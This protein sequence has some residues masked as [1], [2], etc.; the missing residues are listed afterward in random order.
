MLRYLLVLWFLG[1]P[2]YANSVDLTVA[3]FNTESDDDTQPARVAEQ[4]LKIGRFDILV[5]Q[6]VESADALKLYTDTVATAFGGRWRY[7]ISESGFNTD[8]Q[9]DFLGII[10][11]TELFRQLATTELHV[12]RSNENGTPYGDPDWSLRAALVLRLQHVAS[13]KEFQ[14]AT[15]HLKCCDEPGIRTHQTAALAKELVRTGLPTVLLGDTNIP[16]E[17]AQNGPDGSNMQSF[18]NLT[19]GASLEWVKPMNPVKTQCSPKYNSMLDQVYAPAPLAPGSQVEIKFPESEYCELDAQ[20]YADHRPLVAVLPGFLEGE[21][22]AA[23]LA[24]RSRAPA[25]DDPEF[26]EY[27]AQRSGRPDDSIGR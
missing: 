27:L 22:V 16:I 21:S 19:T 11:P 7:V 26:S 6:E 23:S 18:V 4:I 13:G 17:P 8:R 15:V 14:I 5:V 1:L 12:I 20:G 25:T 9:P 2:S 10:Y 24:A 3:T